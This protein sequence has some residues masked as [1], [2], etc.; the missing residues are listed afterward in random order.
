VSETKVVPVIG[1]KKNRRTIGVFTPPMN[2]WYGHPFLSALS[3][4][5]IEKDLNLICFMGHKPEKGQIYQN[6]VYRLATTRR[7]DGLILFASLGHGI[8]A[9]EMEAF[10]QSFSPLPI[11]NFAIQVPGFPTVLADSSR[12]MGEM[13][14]HLIEEHG[15]QRI[16][17]IRGPKGQMEAELRYAAYCQSL[18]EH[19]L[20]LDERIIMEGDYS[21]ESGNEAMRILLDRADDLQAIVAANDNMAI[22][23][24][25]MLQSVGKRV[26]NDFAITGFD[27][28]GEAR[29]V[30][31]PLTT[32]RQS[33]YS[34][35][36][37][38]AELLMRILEGEQVPEVVSVPSDLVL[39]ESCGC[40]PSLLRKLKTDRIHLARED[41]ARTL[42][43]QREI[44]IREMIQALGKAADDETSWGYNVE[45]Q[46]IEYTLGQMWDSFLQEI[47]GQQQD[48]F[49]Q[50]FDQALQILQVIR[51][52]RA[53][54]HEVLSAMRQRFVPYLTDL[55]TL[56]R[57]ETLL[58]QA[59]YMVGEAALRRQIFERFAVDHYETLFQNF[60][61]RMLSALNTRDM[62][63]ALEQF[64]PELWVDHAHIVTFTKE[65][66][67]TAENPSVIGKRAKLFLTY[68][69]G[70][71]ILQ[72]EDPSFDSVNLLP[73]RRIP[74]GR[75]Y[76]WVIVPL[77]VG[78]RQLGFSITE[79]GPLNWEAYSQLRDLV[80]GT[81]FRTLL[82]EEQQQTR[83]N[84]EKLLLEVNQRAEEL[85]VA[86]ARADAANQQLQTVLKETEGLF[87]A[88]QS[89]L[90]ATDP[91]EICQKLAIQFNNIVQADRM[92]IFIVDHEKREILV[93][94]YAGSVDDDILTSYDEL[95]SGI[96]GMVF[97][98]GK[99]VLSLSADDGIEPEETRERRRRSG[100]GSLIVAPLIDK[101]RVIGT[102]TAV[103]RI[104]QRQFNEHD[105]DLLMTLATQAG[106]AIENARLTAELALFNQQLEQMVQQRT[107][108][109]Q[110]A[111][112]QLEQLDQAKSKFISVTS[113][114]LRTPI[115]VIRGYSQILQSSSVI[116]AD[117]NLANLVKGIISGTSRMYE[118]VNSMLD[119]AK[120]DNQSLQLTVGSVYLAVLIKE[121]VSVF[122][123]GLKE[124]NLTVTMS[125]LSSLPLIEADPDALKKVFYHLIGN[126]IKYTPDGGK[127][128]ISGKILPA[129]EQ[130]ADEAVEVIVE[131]TGIGIDPTY[132]ELIFTKF[133]Q[134]G[135]VSLHSTSKTKFKGGGPGLGLTIARGIIVAHG[136]KLWAESPG[137]DEK[138]C[139]GS[140]FHVV[141]PVHYR[142]PES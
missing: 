81:L 87:H 16:A 73:E 112:R 94:V 56:E 52:D 74:T 15:Y 85:A 22:G 28:S 106:A 139:P 43:A 58:Q 103:N 49:L 17:F 38:A 140:K 75:R 54:W 102:V 105:V 30:S 64:F 66:V 107:E 70:K 40:K 63:N 126:A 5:A 89:I 13:M 11:V 7:L 50:A 79:V 141:L 100:T 18:R 26:P 19:G 121:Q 61:Y 104:N 6:P 101:G 2:N 77:S 67:T 142:P 60:D 130:L 72:P 44:A 36:R 108:E 128:M 76:S 51:R 86:K 68:N 4:Y 29:L 127:I 109:V 119:L 122:E 135:E 55:Q 134:T 37:A 84:I 92:Y 136:G 138:E 96:S 12:V 3:D 57:A 123:E 20:D 1:N 35:G 78:D 124:R 118:L 23:A 90:G 114:E 83:E 137:Y 88:A 31:P 71:A 120:I 9:Q 62:A 111:Y 25:E 10:C 80:S 93:S 59:R 98:S 14:T 41:F 65:I 46:L 53:K 33:F 117:E 32:V 95:S 39:R 21:K 116:K 115:T 129:G 27:D 82:I 8:P 97:K 34:L 132:L 110:N 125:G 24:L 113:H 48:V 45:P 131:D 91:R 47:T 99:P 42:Q 133:F 69:E